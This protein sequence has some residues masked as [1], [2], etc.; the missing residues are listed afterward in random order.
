[1]GGDVRSR[2]KLLEEM[3]IGGKYDND[4]DVDDDDDDGGDDG[5][6]HEGM[7]SKH[8]LSITLLQNDRSKARWKPARKENQAQK[9]HLA[10]VCT[11]PSKG[12]RHIERKHTGG[13]CTVEQSRSLPRRV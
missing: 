2:R 3:R 10:G 11:M 4:D 6:D 1:M 5:D 9:R 8:F 13:A 12:E 7:P